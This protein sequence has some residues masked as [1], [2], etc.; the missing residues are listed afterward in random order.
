M[1]GVAFQSWIVAMLVAGAVAYLSINLWRSVRRRHC[2]G[3]GHRS[4]EIP[5]PEHGS[6]FAADVPANGKSFIPLENVADLARRLS[7]KSGPRTEARQ[8]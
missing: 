5:P 4:C 2:G 8:P 6:T 1:I 7:E 3:C